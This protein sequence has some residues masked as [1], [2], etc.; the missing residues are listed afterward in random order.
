MRRFLQIMIDRIARALDTPMARTVREHDW[1]VSEI[2][3]EARWLSE[4]G[5]VTRTLDRLLA[6][7]RDYFRD[8][9]EPARCRE[10]SEISRYRED[11]RREVVDPVSLRSLIYV[12]APQTS[13]ELA[14]TIL[15]RCVVYRKPGS[16]PISAQPDPVLPEV[17]NTSVYRLHRAPN[18]PS[19]V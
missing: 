10:Q 13:G 8:F 19:P 6:L 4:F 1:L 18:P 9:D 12:N 15:E 11:L 14:T 2:A 16:A 17:A 7:K 3:Y 5:L